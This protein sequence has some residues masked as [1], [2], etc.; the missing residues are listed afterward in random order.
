MRRLNQ[1]I[2]VLFIVATVTAAAKP[3]EDADAQLKGLFDEHW[4]FVLQ[5]NPLLATSRGDL[6]YNDRLRDESLQAYN[7]R[8]QRRLEFLETLNAIERSQLSD[9]NQLNYDLVEGQLQRQIEEFKFATHLEPVHQR[10]GFHLFLPQLHE[11]VPLKTKQHYRDY[12]SRLQAI[13]RFIEQHL[14]LLKAGLE[15]QRTPPRHVLESV[16]EQIETLLKKPTE[17]F[18]L[19][20]PFTTFPQAFSET[21]K[22]ELRNDGLQALKESVVPA[23]ENFKNFFAEEYIQNADPEI[24]ATKRYPD[25]EAFYAF[26]VKR[27]TTTDLTAQQIHDIGLREVERIKKRML[28]IISETGFEGNFDEFVEFLRTDEQFYY[29]DPE[30]LL[31]GYRDI[32]K[33]M[34]AELPKLF[35]KLPRA[36]YGVRAIPEYAA[37]RATT[38]YYNRPPADGSRPGWF[39]ANTYDLKSRP[40]YEME[41]LAFHEA[42]P[43]HHLQIALQMELENVPKFRTIFGYTAFVEGWGLY[44][45]SLG[46]EVGFYED[47]YSEFGFLSYEMWRALRL[48]VDT[49]MHA[50]GWSR[51]RAIDFML[52]NSALTRTN[53]ENEVDRYIAWPGQALAYKIG[54]MKIRE[55]RDEAEATLGEDFDVRAF[56]DTVLKAGAIPLGILEE[57]VRAWVAEKQKS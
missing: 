9:A 57:R 33:R 31:I 43:G 1:S 8:H 37:P 19:F 14:E 26:R 39:Y 54:Q 13:P 11:R 47:P 35:G 28:E 34:D 38:A 21:T 16:P 7:Q 52:A 46:K 32:C 10:S 40:K 42:V 53:V 22:S 27:F 15:Q 24:A 51:E 55:L 25:G 12:L 49:G 5:E 44:S 48:V 45:E 36:P 3:T 4:Q 56:H 17:D 29:D 23:F 41:A 20:E 2:F 50:F 30:A 18:P 6:R